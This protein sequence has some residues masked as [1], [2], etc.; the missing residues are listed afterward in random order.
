MNA[1]FPVHVLASNF[2]GQIILLLLYNYVIDVGFL[3]T[4]S[5]THQRYM[6]WSMWLKEVKIIL[7]Q[8]LQ[9]DKP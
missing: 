1:D 8:T 4:T 2:F 5:N 9:I 3:L 7:G 6:K